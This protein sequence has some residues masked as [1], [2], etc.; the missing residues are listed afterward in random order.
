MI[1]SPSSLGL[2]SA[3]LL[4]SC[5]TG[6]PGPSAGDARRQGRPA[7]VVIGL[8]LSLTA[9]G[10]SDGDRTWLLRSRGYQTDT[11]DDRA[12]RLRLLAT[13]ILESCVGAT[14]VVIEGPAFASVSGHA[15]DR[16][17]LWWLVVDLLGEAD[18]PVVE[19]PPAALKKYATG[20]GNAT[21]GGVID[22]TARRFP[23]IDTG[24]DDNRADALWLHAM[25]LDYLTGRCVVPAAQREGLARV[26][27]PTVRPA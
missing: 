8:D 20:K 22:A 12:R 4:Q 21:K 23:K 10:L 2:G 17:G 6:G 7:P 11:L 14:L 1:N 3:L 16:S 5:E 25:G 18:V 27:W 9:T 15:H 13:G 19:V 26:A 24:A